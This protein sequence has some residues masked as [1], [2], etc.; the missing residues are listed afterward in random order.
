[1]DA[2]YTNSGCECG[3]AFCAGCEEITPENADDTCEEC[4]APVSIAGKYAHY[5]Y[6]V[7]GNP[8]CLAEVKDAV[9]VG[10]CQDDFDAR[11]E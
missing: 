11:H 8:E 1:M 4:G 2:R 9:R 5:F 7:C 3:D 10:A 6:R